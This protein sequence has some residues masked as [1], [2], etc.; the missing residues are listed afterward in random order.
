M[1]MGLKEICKDRAIFAR[2]Q[3]AQGERNN[4]VCVIKATHKDPNTGA[5]C[6]GDIVIKFESW[7]RAVRSEAM[8][9]FGDVGGICTACGFFGH[10]D[11][12]Q[13]WVE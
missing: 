3:L 7:G 11:K 12:Q 2:E 8:T 1:L 10:L 13:L 4:S 5:V 9:V 6:D